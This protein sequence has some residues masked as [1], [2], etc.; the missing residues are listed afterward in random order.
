MINRDIKHLKVELHSRL[1][2]LKSLSY[3]EKIKYL[4]ANLDLVLHK[5]LDQLNIIDNQ[6][7]KLGVKTK[8]YSTSKLNTIDN[9]TNYLSNPRHSSGSSRSTSI[10]PSPSVPRAYSALPNLI[11]NN[12]KQSFKLSTP[13]MIT[14]SPSKTSLDKRIEQFKENNSLNILEKS[15]SSSFNDTSS[16]HSS[17]IQLN[18]SGFSQDKDSLTSASNE[19]L[20]LSILSRSPIVVSENKLKNPEKRQAKTLA[21][22]PWSIKDE[23]KI[24][25]CMAPQVCIPRFAIN[26]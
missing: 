2:L 20:K 16:T 14:K 1:E 5:D 13:N 3:E 10:K 17:L 22:T 7:E 26:V 24:K 18:T 9:N 4:D 12:Q 8:N 23:S 11:Q 21:S 15:K 6:I 19:N 25:L